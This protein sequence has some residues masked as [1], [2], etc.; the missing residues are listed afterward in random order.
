MKPGRAIIVP[1]FNM[2]RLLDHN[3]L[4]DGRMDDEERR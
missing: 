3:E 4:R 1:Q 2:M